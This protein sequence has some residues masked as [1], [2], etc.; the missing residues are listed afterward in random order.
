MMLDK[1][2]GS[3]PFPA[4]LKVQTRA[5]KPRANQIQ[6][7]G[8][9]QY[10]ETQGKC[11]V[12]VVVRVRPVDSDEA[13]G[14]FQQLST[15]HV[16]ILSAHEHLREHE[17]DH[18]CGPKSSQQDIFEVAGR[19]F[20]DHCLQGFNV[21]LF[22]YGQTS[23]GKT[24]TM[25]GN[26]SDPGQFGL[27][28]R[29]LEHLFLQISEAEGREG[30][31]KLKFTVKAS[32]LELYKEVITDLL[33]PADG[34]SLQLREDLCNGVYVEGL[35][36]QEI[37][38]AGDAM[39]VVEQGSARRRT[40]ETRMNQ[41]S[42]RSHAVLT[43]YIESWSRADSDVECIRSS[44]LNLIDLAGSERNTASGATGERLR[45]ACSIN[46]SLTTLGRVISE[47]VEAQQAAQA[48]GA[49]RHIP[50]RD[51][52]LTFLLQDSLGGNSKTLI[53]ACVSPAEAH[54]AE[55]A[56]TLE[57][58]QRAKRIRNR[59]RINRDTRGDEQLLRR[60]IERLKRELEARDAAAEPLAQENAELRRQ[61]E[62]A[63]AQGFP[64][65]T[66]GA[67]TAQQLKEAEKQRKHLEEKCADLEQERDVA[68]RRAAHQEASCSN[69]KEEV[70]HARLETLA[71]R[72]TS[73]KLRSEMA[74][75]SR[76]RVAVEEQLRK[77][78]READA[79]R[80]AAQAREAQLLAKLGRLQENHAEEQQRATKWKSTMEVI[81]S[82]MN[83]A[84]NQAQ[85][86][87][88]ESKSGTGR[89]RLPDLE[90]GPYE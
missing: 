63:R 84:Y 34:A 82:N 39:A 58:A 30:P 37:L 32:Y 59:A 65:Q 44:R 4:R 31:D 17:F 2:Q 3:L 21:S 47:L 38:N 75:A 1:E 12:T 53:V 29:L 67:P 48:G 36:E 76:A 60:E 9:D 51:S 24:H 77:L 19:P 83:T 14:G 86:P 55:T 73:A 25:T 61:L 66:R 87:K 6:Q 15:T 68:E 40:N 11:P 46:Q 10:P 7:L 57:F 27:A 5:R 45:E 71:E 52:R 23:A 16:S 28:P 41:E 81:S 72:K 8:T 74:E 33:G 70:Q 26:L 22:A 20:M 78:Q 56:S 49:P 35:T 85:T 62:A 18:V 90:I 88:S 89:L 43:V 80:A 64:P 13:H 79:E 50:Y 54:A 69:M 42:S